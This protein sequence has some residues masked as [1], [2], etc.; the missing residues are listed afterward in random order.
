MID[1]SDHAVAQRAALA[2]AEKHQLQ[3]DMHQV[4]YGNLGEL[5]SKQEK[6]ALKRDL[7][8]AGAK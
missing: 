4:R 8:A 2:M 5:Q 6:R 7:A 3:M 1:T